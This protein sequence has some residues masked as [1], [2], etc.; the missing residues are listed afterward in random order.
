MWNGEPGTLGNGATDSAHDAMVLAGNSSE[1]YAMS[2]NMICT[3][4]FCKDTSEVGVHHYHRTCSSRCSSS[5]MGATISKVPT[6]RSSSSSSSSSSS[7]SSSRGAYQFRV[8]S[9][10]CG[11][12][13]FWVRNNWHK[14]KH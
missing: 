3:C 11:G 7:N 1:D 6:P 12:K 9:L 4:V 14:A 8:G 13:P 10:A 2:D 5:N